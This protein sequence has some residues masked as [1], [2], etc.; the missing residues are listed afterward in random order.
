MNKIT[1][2]SPSSSSSDGSPSHADHEEIDLNVE[3]AGTGKVVLAAIVALIFL[4]GL[5]VIGLLPRLALNREF[6]S[7]KASIGDAIVVNVQSPRRAPTT[8]SVTI[9]GNLRP[10]REVTA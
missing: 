7:K 8:V 5:L 1:S 4:C 2:P 3:P 10:W 9:P 6:D